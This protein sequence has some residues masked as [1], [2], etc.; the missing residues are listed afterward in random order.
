MNEALVAYLQGLLRRL[1][2]FTSND[3]PAALSD[4]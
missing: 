2:V 1:I 4:T 3:L